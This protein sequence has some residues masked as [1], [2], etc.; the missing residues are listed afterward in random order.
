M[1]N[2]E[3]RDYRELGEFSEDNFA[4]DILRLESYKVLY[5]WALAN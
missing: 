2:E 4:Y 3:R 1:L 5:S